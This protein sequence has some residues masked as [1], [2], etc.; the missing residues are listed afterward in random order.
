MEEEGVEDA[1]LGGRGLL[2]LG[3]LGKVNI[4]A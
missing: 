3:N 1:D 2:V 4:S